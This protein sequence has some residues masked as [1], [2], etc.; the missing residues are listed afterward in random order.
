MFN[1]LYNLI[2]LKIH[3]NTTEFFIIYLSST[4]TAASADWLL[5]FF[6]RN[7]NIYLQCDQV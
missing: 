6:F 5:K 7:L 2:F 1:Q 3:Y 4:T